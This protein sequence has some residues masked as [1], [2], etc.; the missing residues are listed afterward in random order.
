[1]KF[2]IRQGALTKLYEYAK[3][4]YPERYKDVKEKSFR[5]PTAADLAQVDKYFKGWDKNVKPEQM[6][7]VLGMYA[8][9]AAEIGGNEA[10]KKMG[11]GIAFHLK[12]SVLVNK[13]LERGEKITGLISEKILEDFRRVLYTSYMEEGISPYEVRKRIAGMFEETYRNRSMAIARTETGVASSMA[14][15]ETYERNEIREKEWLATMDDKTRPS[16]AEANGQVVGI[17]EP[18]QVGDAELMHPLDPSGPPEEVINCFDEITEVLTESGYKFFKD[19]ISTDR[20]I[21]FNQS[22]LAIEPANI[23]RIIIEPYKGPM[24]WL[25]S[26]TTDFLMTP[27][28][29]VFIV[30]K[31]KFYQGKY[32]LK[33]VRADKIP[34]GAMIPKGF[35]WQAARVNKIQ[36]A[37]D[38]YDAEDFMEFLGWYLSEGSAFVGGKKEYKTARGYG[39]SKGEYQ[40]AISQ[41]SSVNPEKHGRIAA[42]C[43][44]IF[45]K[46][47]VGKDKIYIPN[48]GL[49]L[50]LKDLGKS[51]E[52]Y[53][54]V[55]FKKLHRE[56]LERFLDAYCLGDGNIQRR[57]NTHSFQRKFFTSSRKMADDIAELLIKTGKNVSF[58]HDAPKEIKFSNGIYRTKYPCFWISENNSK[59]FHI[60][61]RAEVKYD[62]LVYCAQVENGSLNVRRNGKTCWFSNCR[63]DEL[64]VITHTIKESEAWTG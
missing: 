47:W 26:S 39:K 11:V 64:P 53:I 56:A 57:K 38:E 33:L 37:G 16:H 54:P 49:A 58:R 25:K 24:V 62:G 32:I 20:I 63:C 60:R 46:V 42:I 31:E 5:K 34:Y 12:D 44:K 7:K 14:Q 30:S 61:E 10:L 52:K 40:I 28:H 36:V 9:K 22:T 18:F 3:E 21:T 55:E 4:K 23:N 17:D 48:Q 45:S 13:L 8:P 27:G 6:A 19:L 41:S 50:Y 35:I 2:L 43:R 59:F 51:H 15:H 1:M 29:K